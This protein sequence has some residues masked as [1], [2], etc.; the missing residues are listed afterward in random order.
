MN[1]CDC[2]FL[3]ACACARARALFWKTTVYFLYNCFI[4]L[5]CT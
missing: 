4:S 2:L 1:K 3:C 5:F